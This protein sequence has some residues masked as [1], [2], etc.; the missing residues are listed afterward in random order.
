MLHIFVFISSLNENLTFSS[1]K[2]N[3]FRT[4]QI[5]FYIAKICLDYF[6]KMLLQ[7]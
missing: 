4:S 1:I 6:L 3:L 2:M 5:F 7:I